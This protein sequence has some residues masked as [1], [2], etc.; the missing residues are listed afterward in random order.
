MLATINPVF[1]TT[2]TISTGLLSGAPEVGY[3][4]LSSGYEQ[5]VVDALQTTGINLTSKQVPC[6]YIYA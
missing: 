2:V 1:L 5:H 4:A 3:L 6:L